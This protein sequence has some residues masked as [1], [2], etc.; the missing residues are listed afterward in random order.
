MFEENNQTPDNQ[1]TNNGEDLQKSDAGQD[2]TQS[3]DMGE[4]SQTEI[5]RMLGIGG[6]DSAKT[7]TFKSV[8][9]SGHVH[10]ERLPMLEVVF[11]RFVRMMSISLR[12]F[13]SDNIEVS[14]EGITCLRFGDYLDSIPLPAM[15]GVVRAEEWD[16]YALITIDS[17]LIYSMIDVLLGGRRAEGNVRVD[18]RP[19]SS[20][21]LSLMSKMLEVLMA[22][23]STSFDPIS[24]VNFRFE[25]I[26]TNPRFATIARPANAA[27]LVKLA[28]EFEDKQG[29]ME[30]L[31]PYATIEPIRDLLLQS[32]MG[33]KFGRDTAWEGHLVGQIQATNMEIE[34]VLDEVDIDLR[35][36]LNW[37]KGTQ[38]ALNVNPESSIKLI[39]QNQLL[40]KGKMGNK[41]G[42]LAVKIDEV[43][44]GK[45][46]SI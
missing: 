6:D 39:T 17:I 1:T 28:L 11:D 30:I 35:D 34:A 36:V 19:Y 22:D 37:E 4:L 12:N 45:G 41:S 24:V 14:L 7:R 29:F 13:T 42:H 38:I 2:A 16:N 46:E 32:F 31:I 33:E 9:N 15:L 21:E 8:L 25:R 26:E 27:I 18:G 20:I 23:L 5:D 10:Y 44:L 40:F 43:V 3:M